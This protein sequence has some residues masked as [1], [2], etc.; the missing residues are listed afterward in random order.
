MTN[1]THQPIR[2]LRTD[3]TTPPDGPGV[4]LADRL[5]VD[6]GRPRGAWLRLDTDPSTLRCTVAR[7][8][9]DPDEMVVIDQIGLGPIM[10]D[11]DSTLHDLLCL[12]N[13]RLGYWQDYR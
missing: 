2:R 10:V 8:C 9:L 1:R 6:I 3:R 5:S 11:E 4:F 13:G 12:V 7:A